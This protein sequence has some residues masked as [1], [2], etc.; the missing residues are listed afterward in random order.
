MKKNILTLLLLTFV[1]PLLATTTTSIVNST[2]AGGASDGWVSG[3][4]GNVTF[5]NN[6]MNVGVLTTGYHAAVQFES[7]TLASGE[8]LT[9]TFTFSTPATETW[10]T[11]N[12]FRVAMFDTA[13]TL[14]NNSNPNIAAD[15]YM[16][17]MNNLQG[18]SGTKSGGYLYTR[19]DAT[20]GPII[21]LGTAWPTLVGGSNTVFTGGLG[22][23]QTYV[24][25]LTIENT[26][27]QISLTSLLTGGNIVAET[28]TWTSIA[29]DYY[30]FNTLAIGATSI[31]PLA[32]DAV[33]LVYSSIPEASAAGLMLGGLALASVVARRRSK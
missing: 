4:S 31:N 21:N 19:S 18:S 30:T 29:S 27:G 24:Y 12:A 13:T 9:A 2:F 8:S 28:Q 10:A 33:T 7:V 14:P 11:A 23:S 15:G 6:A 32:V 22:A 25:T 5:T 1:S 20:T 26:D 16:V 3:Q 17:S